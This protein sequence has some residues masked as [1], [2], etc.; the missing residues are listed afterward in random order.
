MPLSYIMHTYTRKG[1]ESHPGMM[2]FW[3]VSCDIGV[4]S[5][6][7]SYVAKEAAHS[8]CGKNGGPDT[9]IGPGIK[10]GSQSSHN[11][12]SIH[13]LLLQHLP[14]YLCVTISP[15]NEKR[16]EALPI[17]ARALGGGVGD[18]GY[19]GEGELGIEHGG[20]RMVIEIWAMGFCVT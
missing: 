14:R 15:T 2:V 6:Q 3:V 17:Q 11:T 19:V 8:H 13:D 12:Q 20:K 10:N 5:R 9:H 16:E 18:G 4:K 7:K 1:N